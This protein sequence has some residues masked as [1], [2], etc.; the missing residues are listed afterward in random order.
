MPYLLLSM[1]SLLTER[2]ARHLRQ[3]LQAAGYTLTPAFINAHEHLELNHYP[4]TRF[5]SVYGDAHQWG[6][7]VNAKLDT[8]PYAE[9]R[10]HPLA[11]KLFIGALKN[12]LS[13]VTTVIQHGTPH[14][15][16]FSRHL[17]VRVL[18][19]YTWAH[20]LHF[21]TDVQIRQAHAQ[22]CA[23]PHA[24]FY[25]HLAEGT[26][27]RARAEYP[28]L[29]ALGGV[30]DRTVLIHG[31]GMDSAHIQDALQQGAAL[32]TCPTTNTYLLN[33]RADLTAWQGRWCIGS[34]SRLTADGDL[35]DEFAALCADGTL[36]STQL[37]DILHQRPRHLLGL[38]ETPADFIVLNPH[39]AIP[40][41]ADIWLVVKDGRPLIGTPELM[42]LCAVP[43]RPATLD[44]QPR[45][46]ARPLAYHVARCTLKLANLRLD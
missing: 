16:L 28:R 32:I 10:A 22:A 45:W 26:S 1:T 18:R 43:C 12:L 46:L 20:S 6:E 15:A 35:L 13:G 33:A 25:I 44:E 41:R 3:S 14:S 5:Q 9:L 42:R 29:R 30:S 37:T 8:P 7:D 36:Q 27:E 39:A 11:D 21:S 2:R 38:P 24:K 40:T 17:P 23:T 31:V 34:D 19:K 4:R